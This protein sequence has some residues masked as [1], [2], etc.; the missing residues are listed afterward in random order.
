MSKIKW[1]INSAKDLKNVVGLPWVKD[2]ISALV[3]MVNLCR[4]VEKQNKK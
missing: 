4:S 1:Q 2:E 3:E